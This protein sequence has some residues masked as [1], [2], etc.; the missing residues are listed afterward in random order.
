MSRKGPTQG[1]P[2]QC[3]S[4]ISNTCQQQDGA[5]SCVC[6]QWSLCRIVNEESYKALLCESSYVTFRSGRVGL[7]VQLRVQCLLGV[8]ELLGSNPAPKI[9]PT[10]HEKQSKSKK[11]KYK[12]GRA[13]RGPVASPQGDSDRG[14]LGCWECL[15]WLWLC[16]VSVDPQAPC[17][18]V[19]CYCI[20]RM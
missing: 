7:W 15:L 16:G 2:Q 14:C 20:T 10:E 13:D 4:N 3:D 9:N 11:A 1:H 18:S 12:P 6:T 19:H 5:A 17:L 8:C